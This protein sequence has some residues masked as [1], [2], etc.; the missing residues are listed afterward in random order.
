VL[1]LHRTKASKNDVPA[2]AGAAET[3]KDATQNLPFNDTTL[4]IGLTVL[5]SVVR[6]WK[7]NYPDSVVFDEV[8]FGGFASK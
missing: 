8:H 3:A 5:A 1:T 6:L 4:V 7:I 2:T